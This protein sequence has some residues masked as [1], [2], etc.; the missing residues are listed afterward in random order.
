MFDHKDIC[1]DT[2]KHNENIYSLTT[3]ADRTLQQSYRDGNKT[4]Y[5]KYICTWRERMDLFILRET[6][7]KNF[8]HILQVTHLLSN[9]HTIRCNFYK[10]FHN[11]MLYCNTYD[12]PSICYQT[13]TQSDAISINFFTITCC[14]VIHMTDHPYIIKLTHNHMQFLYPVSQ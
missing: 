2:S 1:I 6:R 5:N 9:W 3:H 12:R 10:L 7:I 8:Q 14:T 11:N 13:D 4:F